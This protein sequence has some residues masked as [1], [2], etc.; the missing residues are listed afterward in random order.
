MAKKYLKAEGTNLLYMWDEKK[1]IT[2]RVGGDGNL[3][4]FGVFNFNPE[5]CSRDM[6]HVKILKVVFMSVYQKTI[7]NIN[8]LLK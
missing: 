1:N 7:S 6:K 8:S 3:E 4:Y 2:I 5:S